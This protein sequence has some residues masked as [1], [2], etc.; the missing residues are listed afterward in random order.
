MF[1]A[2]P[3]VANSGEGLQGKS[4]DLQ[5]DTPLRGHPPLPKMGR[6]LLGT[7]QCLFL[8]SSG[9]DPVHKSWKDAKDTR[10]RKNRKSRHCPRRDLSGA[11]LISHHET[12]A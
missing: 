8:H 10:P 6:H 9:Q 4:A 3:Y 12:C 1:L 2:W 5:M 7:F 11:T